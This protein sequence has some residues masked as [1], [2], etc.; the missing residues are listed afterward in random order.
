M[1]ENTSKKYEIQLIN[2]SELLIDGVI[3]IDSFDE[4]YLEIDSALGKMSIEGDELKIEEFIQNSGKIR[5]KGKINGLFYQKE[6]SKKKK[7]K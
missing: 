2:R 1:P 4:D 3:S 5:I 6:T 7:A